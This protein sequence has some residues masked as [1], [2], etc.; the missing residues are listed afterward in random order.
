M[1]ATMPTQKNLNLFSGLQSP[2]WAYHRNITGIT[3]QY[4]QFLISPLTKLA[5]LDKIGIGYPYAIVC[6]KFK[7]DFVMNE[8]A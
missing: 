5:E 3:I 7:G 6:I 1:I 2:V 4:S 8:P